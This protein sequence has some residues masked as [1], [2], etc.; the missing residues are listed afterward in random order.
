MRDL[1]EV[2]AERRDGIE[3]VGIGDPARAAR[4]DARE[5]PSQIVFAAEFAFFRD[6]KAEQ[7]APD[8]SET[9]DGE[10]VGRNERSP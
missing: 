10:I 8:V 4:G 1:G 6:K 5:A 9:D 7:R 2:P 3:A